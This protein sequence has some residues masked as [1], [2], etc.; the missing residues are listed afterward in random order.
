MDLPKSHVI[1]FRLRPGIVHIAPLPVSTSSCFLI[2]EIS[3]MRWPVMSARRR[4]VATSIA[5]R[6]IIQ[7]IPEMPHLCVRENAISRPLDRTRPDALGWIGLD[8]VL[9]Q[10]PAI[11]RAQEREYSVRAHTSATIGDAIEDVDD[12]AF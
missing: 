12:V 11:D 3:P 10:P 2:P 5:H 1:F 7:R 6:G 9:R 8:E 4:T